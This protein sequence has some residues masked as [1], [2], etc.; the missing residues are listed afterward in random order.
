MKIQ[1]KHDFWASV[2]FVAV[3]AMLIGA[4]VWAWRHFMKSPPY[5]DPAK[6]P[7]AGIDVSAHNGPVD[8]NAVASEGYKFVFIKA[9]EGVDFRDS[10]FVKNYIDARRAGLKIGAYH[11]FRFDRD[12]IDQ[13]QN[14]LGAIGG[15]KMDL[16]VVIDVEEHNN[17]SGVDSTLIADRLLRMVEFLNLVGM[18]VTFYTNRKGYPDYLKQTVPGSNL[19]I[20]SFSQ[21]PPDIEW[22]FWQYDHHG[23]V[24]GIDSDTD[25]NVF[26]GSTTEWTN[27]LNGSIWPYN[28]SSSPYSASKES[29]PDESK[30]NIHTVSTL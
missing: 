7:V 17:A 20:C 26:C 27:F 10:M 28:E 19:W 8:F 11:F 25:L 30:R 24:A 12:G 22:T 29:R 9:S 18:K 1:F 21:V 2:G 6:Y 13:A 16:G 14:L 23:K 3:V 15:R 4:S 5:V